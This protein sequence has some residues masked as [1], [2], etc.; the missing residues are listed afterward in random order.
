MKFNLVVFLVHVRC[1]AHQ[2]NLAAKAPSE[3][4]T[5]TRRFIWQ[6]KVFGHSCYIARVC[7]GWSSEAHVPN[8]LSDD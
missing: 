1:V 3:C 2:I 5:F 8:A 7:V 4:Q 6:F